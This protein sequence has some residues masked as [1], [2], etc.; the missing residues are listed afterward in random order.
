M[1]ERHPKISRNAAEEI[2][3]GAFTFLAA[4]EER[5][6]RFFALTG[7]DPAEMAAI[8]R[9]PSFL[10]GVLDYMLSDETLLLTY[11]ANANLDAAWVPAARQ[12]L[13]G[14]TAFDAE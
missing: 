12:A 1:T 4:D 9:E 10:P 7:F 6:S 14:N 13:G 8:A 3:I 2:A 5:M 11:C